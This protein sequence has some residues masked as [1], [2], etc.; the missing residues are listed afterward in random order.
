M[1]CKQPD[2]E[3]D[4]LALGFCR[5]HYKRFKKWG[6]PNKVKRPRPPAERFWSKVEKSD[7]CWEWAGTKYR[8]GYGKFTVGKTQYLAHRY[9]Y[10]LNIAKI[11]DGLVIDHLCRNR[12][13]VNPAHLEAVTNEENLARGLGYRIMNGMDDSCIHGHKYTQ[14]NTYYGPTRGDIRCRTCAR[15]SGQK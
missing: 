4:T 14:E 8:N 3:R 15:I 9:A 6:D 10:E 12:G 1:T 7:G 2:C 11:P 13:C 5:V